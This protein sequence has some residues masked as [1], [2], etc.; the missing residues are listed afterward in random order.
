MANKNANYEGIQMTAMKRR[1]Y[2]K[3]KEISENTYKRCVTRKLNGKKVRWLT[4]L[5]EKTAMM[6][7]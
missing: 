5:D 2:W 1:K 4:R 3:R 7:P 6:L